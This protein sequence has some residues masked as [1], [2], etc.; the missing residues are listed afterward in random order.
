LPALRVSSHII[1]AT[2]SRY[3]LNLL[4]EGSLG[5]YVQSS[6]SPRSDS[7]GMR[8]GH[9][10]QDTP[11]TP[12][13]SGRTSIGDMGG[14]IS[15]EMHFP[16]PQNVKSI[17]QLRHQITTRNVFALLLNTSIVGLSLHEAL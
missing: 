12:P 6:P 4:D 3:L 15:Y 7:C 14:Q 13:S 16:P 11:L 9:E 17:D 2:N 10:F 8:L 1:E 5:E